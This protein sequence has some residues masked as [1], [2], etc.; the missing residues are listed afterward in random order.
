MAQGADEV[1][2][3]PILPNDTV[4]TVPSAD[5]L[6]S[7]IEQT[8]AE[9]TDTIDAIQ[10]RLSPK[11]VIVEAKD[12][13]T[14]ATVG[15]VKR[16]ADRASGPEG[17]VLRTL[18]DHPVPVALVAALVAGLLA[19]ATRSRRPW[20][21]VAT[22]TLDAHPRRRNRPASAAR[23]LARHTRLVAAAS[24]CASLWVL[25]RQRAAPDVATQQV[26]LGGSR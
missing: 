15:R 13:I 22:G 16:L 7:Q 8:R 3:V 12:S 25:S 11:R 17:D 10:T 1:N 4:T 23:S 5:H 21:Y 20:G 14:D 26:A 2:P 9:M 6:R 19:R 18:R 24:A